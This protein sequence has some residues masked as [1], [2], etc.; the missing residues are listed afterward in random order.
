MSLQVSQC[1]GVGKEL[2]MHTTAARLV[3]GGETTGTAAGFGQM[4]RLPHR[5]MPS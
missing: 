2:E 4:E 1:V 3:R 5:R